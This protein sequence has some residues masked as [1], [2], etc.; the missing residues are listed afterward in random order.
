[1]GLRLDR[2][3]EHGLPALG[4]DTALD[5]LLVAQT[6]AADYAGSTRANR[7]AVIDQSLR[8]AVDPVRS[9][10]GS[11]LGAFLGGAAFSFVLPR[12]RG[13]HGDAHDIVGIAPRIVQRPVGQDPDLVEL[14]ALVSDPLEAHV[15]GEDQAGHQLLRSGTSSRA[16]RTPVDRIFRRRKKWAIYGHYFHSPGVKT[17]WVALGARPAF[18][19]FKGG[20]A[21]RALWAHRSEQKRVALLTARLALPT[22]R[23]LGISR[24]QSSHLSL[25][26]ELSTVL[27]S[28]PGRYPGSGPA[29]MRHGPRPPAGSPYR[30]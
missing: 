15:S 12:D 21:R 3:V 27:V 20:V 8:N 17:G 4:L 18:W 23:N 29:T 11:R 14:L 13:R 6:A 30:G 19:G 1:V 10:T 22:P 9:A 2:L 5:G 26:G 16:A 28:P 24:P 7:R 25:A